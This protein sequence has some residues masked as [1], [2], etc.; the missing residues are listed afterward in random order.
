VEVLLG[1]YNGTPAEPVTVLQGIKAGAPA[2]TSVV[3]AQGS[4]W[5]DELPVLEA[6][7]GAALVTRQDDRDVPGLTGE[8]Y[9]SAKGI[10]QAP[11]FT[12][13]DPRVDFAW[14]AKSPD[15]LLTNEDDFAVRWT[16][17]LVPPVTGSYRLG[18]NAMNT[19]RLFFEGKQVVQF[20]SEHHPSKRDVT[21]DLVAGKRYPIR[22]EFEHTS[23]D[24]TMQLLWH[25][26]GR[27]RQAEA[28]ETARRADAVVLVLGLSP[29]L[30]GEEM[31][32]PVPGFNGGD[33]VSLDLPAAQQQ[34]LEAV[35][36]LG[37][38]TVLV[39]LNGSALAVNWA[40]RHV[41]AILEAR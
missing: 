2:G 14:R 24:A 19:V 27:S 25:A 40:D 23:N 1:N 11:A 29:R 41:P 28:V 9:N 35:T 37:K 22:I 32:V 21:I 8:Y 4:D 13:I 6:V 36:A 16:G 10:G 5:A 3:Y 34:L 30:E 18:V 38:K 7:P 15:P 33:R 31:R 17:E 20:S 26:P 39:M 12:R